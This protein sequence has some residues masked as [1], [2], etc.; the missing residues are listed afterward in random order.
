MFQ[1]RVPNNWDGNS[2]LVISDQIACLVPSIHPGLPALMYQISKE[3]S[4]NM[5]QPFFLAR[6]AEEPK[7]LVTREKKIRE[8]KLRQ[9]ERERERRRIT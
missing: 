9:G 2:L 5:D 7:I 6:E 3:E 8:K 4:Y 1:E